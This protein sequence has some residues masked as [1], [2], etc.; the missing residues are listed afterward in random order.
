MK[1]N[2]ISSLIAAMAISA[3]ALA[4]ERAVEAVHYQV[5]VKASYVDYEYSGNFGS[6][7]DGT[8]ISGATDGE[9]TFPIGPY[10]GAS[11]RALYE[12]NEIDAG[13]VESDSDTISGIGKVFFRN[14]ELGRIALGYMRDR[15][16]YSWTF[17][18]G[19]VVSEDSE[20][21]TSEAYIGL[22]EAYFGPITAALYDTRTFWDSGTPG[23]Y[24][25]DAVFAS[26]QWYATSNVR[27]GGQVGFD[28]ADGI[29]M[30]EAEF[31]PAILNNLGGIYINYTRGDTDY[32]DV[33]ALRVGVTFYFDRRFDLRTRDRRYR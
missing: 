29:Y 23:S 3:P 27:I 12:H 19:S 26:L 14:P 30:I 28:D 18:S 17:R 31:Q 8:G 24:H 16:N 2:S 4:A 10:F 33:N 1:A 5:G 32:F 7:D 21:E 9:I 15:A 6:G 22:V 20:T 25:D 13:D 11:F